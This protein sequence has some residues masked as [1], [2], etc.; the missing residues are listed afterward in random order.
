MTADPEPRRR[1]RDPERTRG[2]IVTALLDALAE[3]ERTPTAKSL[4]T[5]AGV[6]ERTVFVH[7]TD[8]DDLRA[9]AA[10][11]QYDRIVAELEPVDPTMSLVDRVTAL[12]ALRQR[13][14]PLQ[15]VRLIAMVEAV[16]SPAVAT[17]M[18]AVAAVLRAH[19]LDTLPEVAADPELAAI[20]EGLLG[21][22]FRTHLCESVGLSERAASAATVRAVLAVIAA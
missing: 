5:R 16:R 21:W 6:S 7:F 11:Q 1:I 19:V 9:A 3:G 12:T 13:I 18:A 22:G 2:L 15:A 17:Q 14:R 8:L 4:A 20:V 10:A